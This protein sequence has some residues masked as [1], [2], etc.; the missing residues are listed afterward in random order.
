[1]ATA[2]HGIW[3]CP[4]CRHHQ[5]WKTRNLNT[6]R[7][8]RQCEECKNRARVTLD[9]SN[10]G[11]GRTRAVEIWERPISVKLS[12]LLTEA[13]RR[14][15][16]RNN[17]DIK[18]FKEVNNDALAT[19]NDMPKLWGESWQPSAPLTF[20]NKLSS[21]DV[22]DELLRFTAERYDGHLNLISNLWNSLDNPS[23]FTGISFHDF[24]L[25]FV[26][27][28]G[29]SLKERLFDPSL[30]NLSKTEI[31]PR[32]DGDLFLQRRSTRFLIDISLCLRRIAH[33]ASVTIHQRLDW[34][35]WMIRTRLLD[36]HLKDLYANGILA[37]DG[38]SFTGKGFRS[39]WQE[40][41]VACA[42]ALRSADSLPP[43]ESHKSDII[44]PM[45]RDTGLALAM[46]QTPSEIFAAQMGK[47]ESYMDGGN[48]GSG[49]RDLHIG[50]WEKGIMPPAAPLPIA[51]ATT[52]GV[53][54]AASRLNIDRFHLAP[55]G[56]GCSSSGEF[57][58]AMNFAGA[59]GLPI[60]YMIQNNQ[61]ALDTFSVGQSGAETYGD[62]GYS[63]GIPC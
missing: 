26:E 15:D 6:S 63:M 46:G 53:A 48:T 30:A 4:I 21:S 7:L 38:S 50:N 3:K 14:N 5:V 28:L 57:W 49:G 52:T 45:I 29:L 44:A 18:D 41:I 58:E 17:T 51:S 1:M 35:R 12:E 22:R 8:D 39:T 40:G 34:Q 59:R 25:S 43:E 24:S 23:K 11:Q 20:H 32:R 55:V 16:A 37:P 10:S 31:I 27:N 61:I 56:E 62:K 2:R 33:Y 60:S 47:S 36:E 54:L 42:S 13:K 19:Q 9:R